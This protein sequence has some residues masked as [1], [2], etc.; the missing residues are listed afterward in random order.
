MKKSF[1]TIAICSM[2]FLM[3]INVSAYAQERQYTSGSVWTVSMVKTKANMGV[4]YLNSLKANWKAINDEAKAQGLILSYK[5][6][7]GRAANPEDFD[8]MLM[9]ETKDLASMEGNEAK[10]EAIRKKVM[11]GEDAIKTVNQA[12]VNVREMYGSKMMREVIYK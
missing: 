11:G 5:I 2:F 1:S 9:V 3:L 12:R 6:L 10:W 4:E 8:I 7:D